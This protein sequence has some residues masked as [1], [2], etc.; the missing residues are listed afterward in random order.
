MTTERTKERGE[1]GE[2]ER[3]V[4]SG[5]RWRFRGSLAMFVVAVFAAGIAAFGPIYLNSTNQTILNSTLGTAP[6]ANKGISLETS[7]QH[8]VPKRLGAAAAAVPRPAHGR[9]FGAP[10]STDIA[11]Y[12][13]RVGDQPY[14]G[15]LVARTGVCRHL[16]IVNGSCSTVPGTVLLSTRTARVLGLSVGQ[17]LLPGLANGASP[18]SGHSWPG[19]ASGEGR[20]EITRESSAVSVGVA[21]MVLW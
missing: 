6:A 20:A 10:I 11:V 9:W 2:R 4:L 14:G 17:R 5:L 15:S 16:R 21:L 7:V 18:F 12:T 8:Y 19:G 3:L 1:R 13:V